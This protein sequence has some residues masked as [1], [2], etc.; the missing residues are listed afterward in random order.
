M[1]LVSRHAPGRGTDRKRTLS[2]RR[3]P[4]RPIER[5]VRRRGADGARPRVPLRVPADAAPAPRS[6]PTQE[7]HINLRSAAARAGR[8]PRRVSMESRREA[9]ALSLSRASRDSDCGTRALGRLASPIRSRLCLW[10]SSS[11]PWPFPPVASLSVSAVRC[12]RVVST[13]VSDVRRL[14]T[15]DLR[16]RGEICRSPWRGV[17]NSYARRARGGGAATMAHRIHGAFATFLRWSLVPA[18]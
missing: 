8:L 2:S 3:N 1:I 12:T 18:S 9:S 7:I 17:G 11:L 6:A 15:L 14:H 16:F 4:N 13:R 10:H 5:I